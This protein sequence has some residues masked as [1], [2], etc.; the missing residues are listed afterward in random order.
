VKPLRG[1]DAKPLAWLLSVV[2]IRR[3]LANA[4]PALG[5]GCVHMTL[6]ECTRGKP[7]ATRTST[8][9]RGTATTGRCFTKRIFFIAE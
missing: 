3:Y 5:G 6:H 7:G 8:G 9:G 2:R 1:F 4:S